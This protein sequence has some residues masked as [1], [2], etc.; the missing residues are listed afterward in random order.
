M[1]EEDIILKSDIPECLKNNFSLKKLTLTAMIKYIEA[2]NDVYRHKGEPRL[3]R[4]LFLTTMG[5]VSGTIKEIVDNPENKKTDKGIVPNIGSHVYHF[6]CNLIA[7]WES[8]GAVTLSDSVR[9][10][11][12]EDVTVKS[13]TTPA[14]STFGNMILFVD[15]IL[16]VSTETVDVD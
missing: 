6:V 2:F 14:V 9:Y 11:Y 8:D 7:K 10:V 13:L 3:A 16:G 4:V 5:I 12:L 15:Q 1:E